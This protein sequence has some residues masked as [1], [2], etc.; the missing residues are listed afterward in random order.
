MV[1]KYP[2]NPI[3][4]IWLWVKTNGIHFGVGAFTTHLEPILVLGLG[5]PLGANRFGVLT[6]GYNLFMAS[7]A[8]I[9]AMVL[10]YP[11][12]FE[13]FLRFC[14]GPLS[15]GACAGAAGGT[16][17]FGGA[18]AGAAAAA[19]GSWKRSGFSPVKPQGQEAHLLSGWQPKSK[20]FYPL[21]L[22]WSK[23]EKLIKFS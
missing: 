12:P 23:P 21:P 14:P 10:K 9:T 22:E 19:G 5:C 11:T 2:H 7:I 3:L 18:G 15:H 1:S 16:G 13:T 4:N 20:L 17:G 8:T 6:H